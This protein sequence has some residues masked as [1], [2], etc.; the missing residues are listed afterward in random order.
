MN[1]LHAL[2][3]NTS[4]K[5][6]VISFVG[7]GGKTTALFQLAKQ[8]QVEG[9]R[10][11]VFV[12]TTTHLGAWQT[13]FA[14]HHI[15]VKNK[16]DLKNIPN[17][18][19]I[20]FTGDVEEDRTNPIDEATLN[21][22]RERH[23]SENIPLLIEADGSRQ[24]PLKS[25]AEHEPPIPEFTET[26]IYII[27]LS[28]IGKKLNDEN[29]HRPEIF[30]QLTNLEINKNITPEAMVNALTH[31]QGGL[32]NVPKHAKRIALLNQA[33]TPELQ[34]LGG[35]MAKQLLNH[36]DSVL[37]GSLH[38]DNFHTF[39][40]T[41][42]IILAAGD[43]T[44]FGSPKQLLDWKGKPFVR[45]VTETALRASLEPVLVI[46]GIHHAEIESCLQGLPVTVIQNLNHKD[47]QSESIKL[48][49][50]NLPNTI[51]SNIFLLADQPQIP[52]EVIQALKEKHTQTLSPIIAPLVLEERR[53]N[54][55]LFDKVAFPDLLQLTGDVGGRAI[56][57]KHRVEYLPWHDD[58]LIFDV[59]TKEDYER[60]KGLE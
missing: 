54:A 19:I 25:P 3:I 2:R 11:N 51:G 53:A 5:N 28:T 22:L 60:L 43:S 52:V 48:G 41:A 4:N 47:G 46:S 29:V 33:D 1:L 34:S 44:R 10:S 56:F 6:Q 32:K 50:K 55:V 42:G 58:I 17:E 27:G 36:F 49:I 14:D 16:N 26:V 40:K 9:R 30:S 7:A 24:K 12:T 21:R 13:K 57:D 59:D 23:R 39:E 38:A 35:N 15:V 45:H 20:L 37:V 31:P 18:G 8:F